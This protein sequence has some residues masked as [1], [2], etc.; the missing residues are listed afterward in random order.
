MAER[1][2]EALQ[3][4][5]DRAPR[6]QFYFSDGFPI[7]LDLYYYTG[8]HQVAPGKSQTYSVE[9]VNGE[10]RY[11][12]ARL[13]RATRCFS[14]CMQALRPAIDLFVQC[15]NARQLHK[16]AQPNYPAPLTDFVPM[17]V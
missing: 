6:A 7:Y 5:V 16:R 13:H 11:Y 3:D 4:V 1:T 15:W 2:F 14:K 8:Q 17:R 10:L 12:L 9:G